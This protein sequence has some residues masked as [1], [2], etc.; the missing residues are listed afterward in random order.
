MN[1]TAIHSFTLG[2]T[3]IIMAV[4]YKLNVMDFSFL[5]MEEGS[6]SGY[7][8]L[9]AHVSLLLGGLVTIGTLPLLST[10]VQFRKISAVLLLFVAAACLLIQG[11]PI[12][13]WTLVGIGRPA[14]LLM[15]MLHVTVLV[16]SVR[17]IVVITAHRTN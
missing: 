3:S 2:I 7:V 8:L 16:L 13:W 6:E 17:L 4:C 5:G 1:K 14:Y 12:F 9:W 11:P 15:D 10:H